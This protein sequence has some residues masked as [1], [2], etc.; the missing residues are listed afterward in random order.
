LIAESQAL[1]SQALDAIAFVTPVF[2]F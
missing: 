2:S 1:A